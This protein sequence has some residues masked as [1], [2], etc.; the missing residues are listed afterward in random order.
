MSGASGA[1]PRKP[2]RLKLLRDYRSGRLDRGAALDELGWLQFERLCELVLEAEPAWPR[3]RGRA[4]RTRARVRERRAADVG[5]VARCAPPVRVRCVVAARETPARRRPRAAATRSTRDVREPTAAEGPA[6]SCTARPSCWR[7]SRRLPE[8]RFKLP[9]V[10]SLDA[11]PPDPAALDA[12]HAGPRG[13][14]RALARVFVPTPPW[15]RALAVLREHHFAVLTGPPEMGKT[16]IARMLGYALLTTGWEVHECTRPEQVWER[17]RPAAPAA[18]H[19]R[20]RVRLHRV[21]PG[22]RRALGGRPRSHPARR[23]TRRTGSSGRRARRRCTPALRRVHRERGAERFPQPAAVQVDA[24]ALGPEEK[25]LMLFRHARAARLGELELDRAAPRRPRDRRAPALHAR[26]NP[27]LRRPRR[28]RRTASSASCASR[29]RR[30]RRRSPRSRRRTA[31]CWW[32]CSTPARPGRGAR[33]RRRAAPARVGRAP[34]GAGR[35]RGPAHRPLRAGAVRVDWVHP[36][37]RDVVID[38]LATDPRGAPPLPRALR[39]GRHR[40]R[41]SA[42]RAAAAAAGRGLGRARRRA[43]SALPRPRRG[44]GDPAARAPER[45]RRRSPRCSRS[46][47]S[48]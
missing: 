9:S 23:P 28:A 24:S 18:L 10:L 31:R 32:R 34:E 25:T 41:A 4:R 30:W 15:H 26:A 12:L 20:R 36:S 19:R 7:R 39:R 1:L 27:P 38:S 13:A 17:L 16:A 40:A 3:R 37:W 45:R 42:E 14:T 5:A 21:P 43:L 29:P 11:A 35:P 47:G 46:R 33:P 8:L 48:R 44:R 22:R 2:A 6:T